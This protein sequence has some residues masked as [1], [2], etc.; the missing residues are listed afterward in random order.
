MSD[1]DVAHVHLRLDPD[2]KQSWEKYLDNSDFNTLSGLIRVAVREKI[3]SD[4]NN[5]ST[6]LGDLIDLIQ[7]QN[8][9][10]KENKEDNEKLK[11]L[12]E[13]HKNM[14][15]KILEEL[16]EDEDE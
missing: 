16:V 10:L 1:D 6:E 11:R 13:G 14:N 8:D 2:L 9:L 5:R 15:M 7:E 4:T 3:D 12:N